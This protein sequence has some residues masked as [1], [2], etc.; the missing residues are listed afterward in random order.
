MFSPFKTSFGKVYFLVSN[1]EFFPCMDNVHIRLVKLCMVLLI[2]LLDIYIS[3]YLSPQSGNCCLH[4][5]AGILSFLISISFWV[6]GKQF[7]LG[8]ALFPESRKVS[9]QSAVAK[10]IW[11]YCLLFWIIYWPL[12]VRSLASEYIPS[13]LL[14]CSVSRDKVNALCSLLSTS[15]ETPFLCHMRQHT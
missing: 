1:I 12:V 2:T 4:F 7:N 5:L 15:W 14:H 8:S 13:F 6:Y 9:V 3:W 10:Q 11:T